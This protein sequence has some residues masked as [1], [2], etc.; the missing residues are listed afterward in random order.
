MIKW[1]QKYQCYVMDKE[2]DLK[3]P[4]PNQRREK[5]RLN[6]ICKKKTE[7]ENLGKNT[8]GS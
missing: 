4:F 2:Y 7:N 1:Y 5:D 6:H 3:N 8:E